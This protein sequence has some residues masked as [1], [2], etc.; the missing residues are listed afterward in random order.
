[1]VGP[2][3]TMRSIPARKDLDQLSAF[4]NPMHPQRKAIE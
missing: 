3:F 4:D 2:A 1:M